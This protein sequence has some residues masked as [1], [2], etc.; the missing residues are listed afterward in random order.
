MDNALSGL[1]DRLEKAKEQL[2]NLNNQQEAAKAELGKPFPQETELSKKSKR[3][4]ELDAAL[5]MDDSGEPQKESAE[6]D[7]PSVL[8]DLKAKSEQILPSDRRSEG[9]EEVL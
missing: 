4:A 6:T 8:A 3:L 2:A 9:Y 5:N 7:R 1:P